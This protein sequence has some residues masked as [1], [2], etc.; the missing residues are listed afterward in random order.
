MKLVRKLLLC[1]VLFGLFGSCY[2]EFQS[3]FILGINTKKPY[4]LS[5]IKYRV[6]YYVKSDTCK[7]QSERL[8]VLPEHAFSKKNQVSLRYTINQSNVI[9]S[10][11]EVTSV[12]L[13]DTQGWVRPS[14]KNC[15]GLQ[16]DC[17]KLVATSN[18]TPPS[19]SLSIYS[20]QGNKPVVYCK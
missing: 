15:K 3:K 11:V 16:N 2:S 8:Y 19:L 10:G 20:K 1:T 4:S 5:L 18:K 14:C 9:K 6:K 17:S 12:K 7:S 13:R